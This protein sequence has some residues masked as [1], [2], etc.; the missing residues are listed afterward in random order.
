MSQSVRVID[1]GWNKA[2]AASKAINGRAVRVGI[3]AGAAQEGVAVVDYA[4]MNEFGTEDIPARPFMRHT[5][6]EAEGKLQSYARK[7]LGPMLDGAMTVTAVLDAVGLWY[8]ARMR[9]TIRNS[10]SWA[11]ANAPATIAMKG[12]SKPLVD[13]GVLVGSIDYEKT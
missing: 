13:H 4:V 8:Q 1:K 7:L 9:G 6:D 10:P 12:S 5:A 2:L 3:R 11:K